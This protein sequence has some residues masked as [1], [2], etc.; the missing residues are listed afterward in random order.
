M[1]PGT[2]DEPVIIG[3]PL[4]LKWA[5]ARGM[6]ATVIR[7]SHTIPYATALSENLLGDQMPIIAANDAMGAR[8]AGRSRARL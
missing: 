3:K 1:C 8:R 2:Y 7:T 4:K 5:V 6:D